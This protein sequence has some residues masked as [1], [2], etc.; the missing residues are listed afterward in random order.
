MD[1]PSGTLDTEHRTIL[2]NLARQAVEL[3][4]AGRLGPA[5]PLDDLPEALRASRAT[6]VTLTRQG[7][8]RGCIGG[9]QATLPL[10]QDVVE[11]ARAAAT[12]D[13]R[14]Y[15]VRPEETAELEIEV[16]ILSEPV[17][18]DYQH[19]DELLT[20]LR[21]GVDGVI[22]TSGLNRATFLPQVWEKVAQPSVFLDMLCEKAGLPRRAWRTG[23]PDILTYQVESFHEAEAAA[24]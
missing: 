22:L 3:A 20:R 13:F 8:L 7:A 9:L 24:A 5:V 16:S 10:A 2:L 6:F 23:H 4:S 12:E 14:F 15:P 17:P 11:H 19:S 18:L 1:R 21:P